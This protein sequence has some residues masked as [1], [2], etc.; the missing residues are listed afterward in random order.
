MIGTRGDQLV[1]PAAIPHF[2]ARLPNCTLKM[3]EPDVAHEILRERDGPRDEAIALIDV[4]LG[5]AQA[6]T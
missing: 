5:Q 6:A 3:F 4:L 2:A 1:S